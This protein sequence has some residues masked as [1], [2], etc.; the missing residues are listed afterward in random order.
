MLRLLTRQ[1]GYRVVSQRGSHKKLE[2]DGRPTVIFSYH[3]GGTVSP[4]AVK[5]IL[6]RQVG[7]TLDEAKEVIGRA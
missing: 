5:D 2:A 6:V 4:R 3:D 1:L 7:L